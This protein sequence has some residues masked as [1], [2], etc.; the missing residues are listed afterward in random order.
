MP[1]FVTIAPIDLFN[2]VVPKDPGAR[3]LAVDIAYGPHPRQKLDIYGPRGMGDMALPVVV[4]FY[5]GSWDTGSKKSYAFVGRALAAL[6]YIAV[7]PDY[8]LLPE[9]EYPV[10]LTDCADAVTWVGHSI[11]GYGGDVTRLALAGH[12]AGAYNAAMLAL[13]PNIL[14]AR[15]VLADVKGVAGLSGP[16]DFY[17]FDGPI[18]RR[19]FGGAPEP[20][21]TQPIYHVH[22]D[23]PAMWLATG[24]KDQLVLPR[25]SENLAAAL[26]KVG[27]EAQARHYPA[28][29]H[30]GTLLALSLPL[31]FRAPVL[32]DMASFLRRVLVG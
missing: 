11:N 3:R 12:S 4:F 9:V 1:E 10:F 2:F 16:Y 7:I 21:T 28:L 20:N 31:R 24:D 32:A 29:G 22:A 17:P 14:G 25:N 30:A 5:G 8:R 26:R 15:G 18:S 23:S 27:V 19:V 13:A 6:G